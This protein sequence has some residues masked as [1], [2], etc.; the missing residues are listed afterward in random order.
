LFQRF[1]SRL[2]SEPDA[3]QCDWSSALDELINVIRHRSVVI[4]ISDFYT[5]L[6]ALKKQLEHLRFMKCETLF[7]QVLDPLEYDFS[8]DEPVLL[9]DL[10]SN[11]KIVLSPDLLRE[12]YKLRIRTHIENVAETVRKSGGDHLLLQTDTVPLEALSRYLVLR[13]RRSK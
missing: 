3:L 7:V 5:D 2:H 9:Q 4:M 13:S 6:E 12:D 8:Y 11:E 10:E 1:L